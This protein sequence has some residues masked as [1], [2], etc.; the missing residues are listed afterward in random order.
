[1]YVQT[2]LVIQ[3]SSLGFQTTPAVQSFCW[4]QTILPGNHINLGPRTPQ[5]LPT[6]ASTFRDPEVQS[7]PGVQTSHCVMVAA[8]VA[9]ELIHPVQLASVYLGVSSRHG[10]GS[11]FVTQ[12]PSDPES[13]DPET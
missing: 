11:H 8:L 7:I 6:P 4:V 5:C 10:T 3:T 9:A 2:L 13:S 12:R 1:M